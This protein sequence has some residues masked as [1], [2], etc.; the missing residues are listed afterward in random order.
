VKSALFDYER[1]LARLGGDP[2]LF[3]EIVDLFLEDSPMLLEQARRGLGES[4]LE[5]L[6]RSAHS[7]KSLSANFDAVAL[8]QAAAT[9]EQQALEGGRDRAAACFEDLEHELARLQAALSQLQ[10]S[11]GNT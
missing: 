8:S 2:D 3:A 7:L 10:K 11:R 5:L 1:S 4:D 9:V 6:A